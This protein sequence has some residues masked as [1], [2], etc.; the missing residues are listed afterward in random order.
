MDSPIFWVPFGFPP[1][2][3]ASVLHLFKRQRTRDMTRHLRIT[4]GLLLVLLSAS[5]GASE[6]RPSAY[7]IIDRANRASEEKA[8]WYPTKTESLDLLLSPKTFGT[9]PT[10]SVGLPVGV[11]V[12]QVFWMDNRYAILTLHE[13]MSSKAD[14]QDQ[15]SI[16]D[17]RTGAL[18]PYTKG[19]LICYRAGR[20]IYETGPQDAFMRTGSSEAIFWSGNIGEEK[21][22]PAWV[23]DAGDEPRW[24]RLAYLSDACSGAEDPDQLVAQDEGIGGVFYFEPGRKR[25]PVWKRVGLLPEHGFLANHLPTVMNLPYGEKRD[26]YAIVHWFLPS[27]D[28]VELKLSRFFE[29]GPAGAQEWVPWLGRYVFSGA[30]VAYSEARAAIVSSRGPTALSYG[31]AGNAIIFDP[32]TGSVVKVPRPSELLN[33]VQVDKAFATRAGLAWRSQ[34]SK[35]WG[36]YLSSNGSFQRISQ[37]HVIHLAMS[38]DGCLMSTVYYRNPEGDSNINGLELINFC[39]AS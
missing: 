8:A 35:P 27:G 36:I 15:I 2:K 7:D 1:A 9:Y 25:T 11:R 13:T 23:R 12:G 5:P 20:V 3:C 38:P 26:E 17:T 18:H 16:L 21:S 34:G 32:H 6:L 22:S 33:L 24:R 39:K 30:G 19:R 29:V 14:S 4:L 28:R 37:R 31:K 10:T